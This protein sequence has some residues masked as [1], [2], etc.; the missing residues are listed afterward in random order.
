VDNWKDEHL[1]W[2]DLGRARTKKDK[3]W[4]GGEY[5]G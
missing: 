1:S 3:G 2:R 4:E 5:G